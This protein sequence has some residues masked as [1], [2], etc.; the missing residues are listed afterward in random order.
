MGYCQITLCPISR[1]LCTI[2]LPWAKFEYQNL[3]MGLS[4]N[5]DIF[6]RKI[7]KLFHGLEYVRAYIDD[8]LINSNGN[9]KDHLNKEKIVLKKLKAADFKINVDKSFIDRDN[10]KYLDLK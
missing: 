3:P 4:N 7:N 1:K 5:P 6:S 8:H 2:V 10:S 9:F